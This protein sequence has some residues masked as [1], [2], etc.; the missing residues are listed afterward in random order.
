MLPHSPG[1]LAGIAVWAI[2]IAIALIG[3][4]LPERLAG[5]TLASDLLISFL[6]WGGDVNGK[7]AWTLVGEILVSVVFVLLAIRSKR[8]WLR[9]AVPLQLLSTATIACKMVDPEIRGYS[10]LLLG[11][12]LGFTI[13]GLLVWGVVVEAPGV[14]KGRSR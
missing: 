1:V 6:G 12:A 2:A 10:Y 8:V 4:G 13:I 14:G 11:Q 5:L 7:R 9:R 3:G